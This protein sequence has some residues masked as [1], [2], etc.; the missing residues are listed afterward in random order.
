MKRRMKLHTSNKKENEKPMKTALSRV[1]ELPES[2]LAGGLHI[3]M[4]ANHEAVVENCRGVLEY[5][6]QV[7]RLMAGGMVVKF[8]GRGLAIGSL[9]RNTTVVSGNITAVEFLF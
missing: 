2:T 5:T 7:I 9:S 6:P 4:H 3:E 8:S 1:L